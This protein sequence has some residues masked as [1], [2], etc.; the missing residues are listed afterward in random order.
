MNTELSEMR[1]VMALESNIEEEVISLL[2]DKPSI[3]SNRFYI[4]R[5]D[6]MFRI[7]FCEMIQGSDRLSVVSS[8]LVSHEDIIELKSLIS[9]MTKTSHA[10]D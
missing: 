6:H 7:T 8:V 3:Y 2:L 4:T 1:I 5:N 10:K 9:I